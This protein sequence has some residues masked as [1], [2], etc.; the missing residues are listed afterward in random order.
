MNEQVIINL[1]P[2]P[3]VL[4]ALTHTHIQPLDALCEL[5]DNAIDSFS[6]AKLQ[7]FPIESPTVRIDLPK[8]ADI[9][10]GKGTVRISDNGPGLTVEAAEKALRA[11]F[12]GNN[13]YDT[14]GLFGMGFNISTGKLGSVTRFFSVREDSDS[15]VEVTIDLN[16]INET[17]SYQVAAY[18]VDKGSMAH[19]TVV[20]V[21]NW[22]PSGNANRGFVKTLISYGV[23]KIREELGRR[24]ATILRKDE[25][26]IIVNDVKCDAFEHCV[27]DDSRYVERQKH[28]KIPA[29]F[30]FDNV[31]FTQKKCMHCT[32]TL[33]PYQ[34]QC[35]SCGSHEIRTIEERIRGW[36]GIQRFDDLSEFGIDLIR[37]GRAIRISEKSALFEFVDEFQKT[38]K[39]YPIDSNFGRIVGEVHL[40]HVPV[41]FMKQDFQR[42][43]PEWHRA[44]SFLRGDSSL[45]PTQPG[46]D[47]N[48]SPVFKLYQGYRKVK[49]AGKT[50]MYMG[51]WDTVKE[52]PRRISRDIEKEFY[53]RFKRKEP[54]YY[55]D[56]E[57]WKKVEE[58]DKKPVKQLPLCPNCGCQNLEEAEVCIGCGTVL[59]GK[60]CIAC[61]EWIPLSAKVCPKCG[62]SQEAEIVKPWTCS[63]CGTKNNPPLEICSCCGATKDAEN[64]LSIDYLL[65]HSE[66]DDYLSIPSCILELANGQISSPLKVNVYSMNC[67]IKS[68]FD[69][70]A[71]PVFT[72]KP[73]LNEITIFVDKSHRMFKSCKASVE[74]IVAGEIAEHVY[75]LNKSVSAAN[76]KHSQSFLTWQ[77]IEKYWAERLED[78]GEE[79]I[80]SITALFSSIRERLE[81]SSAIDFEAAFD[82]LSN[83]QTKEMVNE[84]INDGEDIS[85]LNNLKVSGHFLKYVP[86]SFI[87]RLFEIKPEYFFD[88]AV[89][90]EP[91]LTVDADD[92]IKLFMQ[93]RTK[94]LYQGCLDDLLYYITYKNQSEFVL[95]KTRLAVEL[96]RQKVNE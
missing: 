76:G 87:V 77:I 50:D 18:R 67:S 10:S 14:L 8:V 52:E 82:M 73:L 62:K 32:A 6:T 5:I 33:E 48:T 78:S 71:M 96:L 74:Q 25:I 34:T 36:V 37:N 31:V 20:E 39:D 29:V 93:E 81:L 45:Q 42:S 84:I 9:E 80:T 68:N 22:W 21:S 13:P 53:E 24:Y 65:K 94:A 41:D 47:K 58:A 28:G 17:K 1:T 38:I 90:N 19:G 95:Q 59:R 12:S 4:I 83:D 79:L 69:D 64:Y 49:T 51:V 89:W 60:N 43:S 26:R 44:I 35:P 2:D 7:G 15:A 63:I 86:I 40:N 70:R 61:G 16:K 3:K 27:W 56:A 85:K 11:G 88:G 91:Y 46:A 23:K 30:R 66:K 54:G 72:V 92:E 75:M 55:D 57:W